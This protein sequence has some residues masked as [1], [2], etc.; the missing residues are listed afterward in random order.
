MRCAHVLRSRI[1]T[2]APSEPI[3]KRNNT[4]PQARGLVADFQATRFGIRER[5]PYQILTTLLAGWQ[6][7][8][9]M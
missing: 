6:V 3:G 8:R 1:E 9:A 5:C 7:D 4:K 2:V